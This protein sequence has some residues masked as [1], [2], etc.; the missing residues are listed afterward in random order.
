[1]EVFLEPEKWLFLEGRPLG[2][3]LRTSRKSHIFSHQSVVGDTAQK[4]CEPVE[5]LGCRVFFVEESP[6]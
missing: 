3:V 1:M 2:G 5:M 4:Y 6:S